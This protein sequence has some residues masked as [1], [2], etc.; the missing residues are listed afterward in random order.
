M[1]EF[2]KSSAKLFNELIEADIPNAGDL[3]SAIIEIIHVI[4][5][6]R[7]K[8]LGLLPQDFENER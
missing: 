5:E 4:C 6:D 7:E 1:K 8:A 2:Q 3:G